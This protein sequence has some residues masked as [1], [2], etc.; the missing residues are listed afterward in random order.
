VGDIAFV[1]LGGEVFC[2]IGKEIK[3]RSP[4]AVTFVITHSSGAAGYLPTEAAYPE[5]GYE[6]ESSRFGPAAAA[7]A[8][9]EAVRLLEGIR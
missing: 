8:V 5:G 4:F 6:V 9:R 7:I 2:E 1:G 3:A